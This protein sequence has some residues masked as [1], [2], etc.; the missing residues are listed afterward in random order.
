MMISP[1]YDGPTVLAI[2]GAPAEQLVPLCRQH[3]RMQKMVVAMTDEQ[4]RAPSRCDGWAA[5]DVV[6][7]LVDVNAFWHAS[8][9]AGLAGARHDILP[10]PAHLR[11]GQYQAAHGRQAGHV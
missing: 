8:I 2:D 11:H 9:A 4:L 1:R 6:A 3:R 5:R 10:A 7:H